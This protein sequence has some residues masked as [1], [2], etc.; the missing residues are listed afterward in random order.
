MGKVSGEVACVCGKLLP[1]L[2]P[3]SQGG[4]RV[5]EALEKGSCGGVRLR[6]QRACHQGTPSLGRFYGVSLGRVQEV[7]TALW[8]KSP[9]EPEVKMG[10]FSQNKTQVRHL[11]RK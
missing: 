10:G 11:F 2:G 3:Q 9:P 1:D 8:F 6:A 7:T 4:L 5:L